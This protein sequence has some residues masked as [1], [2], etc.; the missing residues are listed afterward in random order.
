M[1]PETERI[2]RCSHSQLG[3]QQ[4]S[5]REIRS[6]CV[7]ALTRGTRQAPQSDLFT[8]LVDRLSCKSPT[9][10]G[11]CL[12]KSLAA[13]EACRMVL[14]DLLETEQDVENGVALLGPTPHTAA[15][16]SWADPVA[17]VLD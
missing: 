9:W 13:L 15:D 2:R 10:Q 5:P 4:L 12:S 17:M 6:D 8:S 7:S 3:G 1:S 14:N 11:S 16:G